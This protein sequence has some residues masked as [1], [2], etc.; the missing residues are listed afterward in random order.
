MDKF[1]IE[2]LQLNNAV[3]LPDFG[4]IVIANENTGEVMFNEYLKFNDGKLVALIVAN[5]T[6]DAQD[7]SNMV[8]KYIRDIQ[9]QLDKGESY[10][11]FGL[12]S[13]QKDKGG[14]AIFTGNVNSSNKKEAEIFMGPSPT[15]PAVTAEEENTPSNLVE[16]DF[17]EHD[18]SADEET[19]EETE[20]PIISETTTE[21]V[22]SSE[23]TFSEETPQTTDHPKK[24]KATEQRKEKK[25]R[26]ILFWIL[27]FF[28]LVL[29]VGG[30]FIGVKYE[31]VITYMGW[32]KF[33]DAQKVADVIDTQL[34]EE[35]NTETDADNARVLTEENTTLPNETEELTEAA[36]ESQIVEELIEQHTAIV[37]ID[38]KP[39]HLIGGSFSDETNAT[40]FAAA[41]KAKGLPA[42]VIGQFDGRHMVSVK[43]F[44]SRDEAIAEI[45]AIQNEAPGA[46]L[47]KSPK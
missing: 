18:D 37:S 13:F 46:W 42:H 1:L 19:K 26:G 34:A 23:S 22:E 10:D 33:S 12:G 29:S 20:E 5:S 6:M 47:F 7:A 11:I 38:G 3:I 39:F 35:T 2:L 40:N 8:A 43:S 27:I 16:E 45:A 31:E 15:P 41:L 25:K 14:S 32:G 4:S 9:I 30:V 24:E 17:W 36:I 44:A 21:I 28:L